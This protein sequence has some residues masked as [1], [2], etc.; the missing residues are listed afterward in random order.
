MTSIQRVFYTAV[1]NQSLK[2]KPTNKGLV[3]NPL[4]LTGFIDGEGSFYV[5]IY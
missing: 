3:I 5:I 4:R 1:S 2:E